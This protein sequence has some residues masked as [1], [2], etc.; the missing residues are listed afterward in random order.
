MYFPFRQLETQGA[1]W[2]LSHPILAQAFG[3]IP[4]SDRGNSFE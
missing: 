4:V 2:R 1:N 3:W